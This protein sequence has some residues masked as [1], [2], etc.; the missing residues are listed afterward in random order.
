V[1]VEQGYAPC[2][3]GHEQGQAR[4]A[5]IA[6]LHAEG[7]ARGSRADSYRV[8]VVHRY[9]FSSLLKRMS[10]IIKLD[11]PRGNTLY[12]VVSKGAP[13][14]LKHHMSPKHVRRLFTSRGSRGS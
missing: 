3:C 10:T 8:K 9:F 2:A 13:E 14:V 7:N 11:N 12:A 5:D 6:V 1:V 4:I